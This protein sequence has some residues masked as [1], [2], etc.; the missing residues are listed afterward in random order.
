MQSIENSPPQP[1]VEPQT[2]VHGRWV[3]DTESCVHHQSNGAPSDA[4]Q[5]WEPAWRITPGQCEEKDLGISWVFNGRGTTPSRKNSP[6]SSLTGPQLSL[7][8]WRVL[9]H[10]ARC[11]DKRRNCTKIVLETFGHVFLAILGSWKFQRLLFNSF[12]SFTKWEEGDRFRLCFLLRINISDSEVQQEL[13]IQ[14]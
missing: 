9:F 4:N 7:Q 13:G 5:L 1:W 8:E 12:E 14:L 11:F 10:S 3:V 2:C 6:I